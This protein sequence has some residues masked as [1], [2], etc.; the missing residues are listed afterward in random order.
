VTPFSHRTCS[1]NTHDRSAASSS[2][3][4]T[5]QQQTNPKCI[6]CESTNHWVTQCEQFKSS[7][8]EQRWQVAKAGK[9]CFRCLKLHRNNCRPKDCGVNGFTKKHH[10]LLHSENVPNL[11]N[12]TGN[13]RHVST[14]QGDVEGNQFF[15]IVPVILHYD[16][17]KN[18]S[19]RLP[20]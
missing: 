14:H 3:V 9:A 12:E 1:V 18:R 20:G 4:S 13:Q 7:A 10:P 17:K 19:F 6:A 5:A 15:R 16:D 2:Q 8:V 11:A